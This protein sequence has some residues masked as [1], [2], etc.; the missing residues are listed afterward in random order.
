MSSIKDYLADR[1]RKLEDSLVP[2]REELS[3]TQGKIEQIERELAD[4]RN[5]ARAIGIA[6]GLRRTALGV[7]RRRAPKATIKEAVLTILA[8]YPEG[9]LALDLLAKINARYDWNIVRESLSP[10]LT[11]LKRAH[12]VA[13]TDRLWHLPGDPDL[14]LHTDIK[15]K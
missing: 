15:T 7:T 1:L 11:R 5:A 2:L 4:A 8:D 14:F 9:L 3:K 6:N 12:K 10:Q 13:N